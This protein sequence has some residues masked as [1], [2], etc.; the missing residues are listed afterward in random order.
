MRPFKFTKIFA[1]NIHQYLLKADTYDAFLEHSIFNTAHFLDKDVRDE[2][3]RFLH[4]NGLSTFGSGE[5]SVLYYLILRHFL[6]NKSVYMVHLG[7]PKELDYIDKNLVSTKC[8]WWYGLQYT[9]SEIEPFQNFGVVN[10]KEFLDAVE[11]SNR[12]LKNRYF[13]LTELNT[14][15]TQQ[16]FRL[17][18]SDVTNWFFVVFDA[19]NKVAIKDLLTQ[20]EHPTMETLLDLADMTINIQIG[21]DE[22]YLDC[23]LVQSAINLD[24][25]IA[26]VETILRAKIQTYEAALQELERLDEDWKVYVYETVLEE[27]LK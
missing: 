15:Q 1:Q 4:K 14:I 11:Y 5:N 9:R 10:P 7:N 27:L 21:G 16:Y 19:K 25:K 8:E 13:Y 2:L 20:K 12:S 22:G 17:Y 3:Y 24:D 23:V 26:D 18:G 6:R